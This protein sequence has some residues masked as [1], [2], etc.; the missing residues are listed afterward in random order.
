MIRTPALVITALAASLLLASCAVAAPS[1]TG[2]GLET[3]APAASSS[4][5]AGAGTAAWSPC[6]GSDLDGFTG[7]I[8]G[9]VQ[10]TPNKGDFPPYMPAP[11]CIGYVDSQGVSIAEYLGAT[12]DDFGTMEQTVIAQQGQPDTGG[13][14][15][16]TVTID[17][18]WSQGGVTDLRFVTASD[19][20]SVDRIE[21]TSVISNYTPGG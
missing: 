2:G 1:S 20:F 8:D 9:T 17:D 4:S 11:S 21:A 19:G 15:S 6:A 10:L 14:L 16:D 3:A 7:S 12:T 18:I 5:S 13:A